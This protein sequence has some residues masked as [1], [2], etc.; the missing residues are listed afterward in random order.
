[1]GHVFRAEKGDPV[2][3]T[4]LLHEKQQAGNYST[5]ELNIPKKFRVGRPRTCWVRNTLSKIWEQFKWF[6]GY[7]ANVRFNFKDPAHIT[8]VED[9]ALRRHLMILHST[10]WPTA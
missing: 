3:D 5:P 1:M 4:V 9:M 6:G 2:R 7:E 8:L 10:G